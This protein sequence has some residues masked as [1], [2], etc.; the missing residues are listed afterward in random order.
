M[1]CAVTPCTASL[2]RLSVHVALKRASC[3]TFRA[4]GTVLVVRMAGERRAGEA[5]EGMEDE[6][7]EG[8]GRPKTISAA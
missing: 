4:V 2:L 6:G 7:M 1:G 8:E 5:E 3:P